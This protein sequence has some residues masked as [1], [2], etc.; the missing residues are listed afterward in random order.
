MSNMTQNKNKKKIRENV[1]L[2]ETGKINV[3]ATTTSSKNDFDFLQGKFKVHHKILKS[4]LSNSNEW[5][6]FEGSMEMRTAL[7]GIGNVENHYMTTLDG[8]PV[9]GF[10]LRLFSPSTRL[11][12]IYWANSQTG[13]LDIPVVGSFDGNKGYFFANDHFN[14]KKILLHFEWDIV[15]RSQPIWKQAFSVDEGNTWEWNWYMY[16]MK[17]ASVDADDVV[18]VLEL[19]NY[20]LRP[21]MRREFSNY[22]AKYLIQPQIDK[23]GYVLGQYELKA[24]ADNFLWLRGFRSMQSRS[25][26]LPEFYGGAVWKRHREQANQMMLNSDNV[27]LLRPLIW[28]GY[29]L[30]E[31]KGIEAES[32]KNNQG[33]T[34]IDYYI[35]N[36]K[37]EKLISFFS[38][39]YIPLSRKAGIE[40][41]TIWVSE[42]TENDFP[43]LPV[44]QDKNLLVII[45]FYKE[46]ADYKSKQA[47]LE[48]QLTLALKDQMTDLVTTKSTQILYPDVHSTI[49]PAKRT[50][51]SPKP[52]SISLSF[53]KTGE[54]EIHPSST[55]SRHDY[56]FLTGHHNVHH[57]KLKSRLSGSNEWIEFDGTK[58]TINILTGIGNVELHYMN[59]PDGSTKEGMALRLF[60]PVTRLWSLYW[61]DSDFGILDKP[62]LG[63]FENNLGVFL[64][65]DMLRGKEIIVQFQYDKTDPE[66]PTWGQAFS[67]DGG[68]TWE[69]NWF[70]FYEK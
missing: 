26:F 61:A 52:K 68:Q 42:L 48:S 37:L 15:N 29:T 10:A 3:T 32:L 13:I 21:G 69:W 12:S 28:D 2:D 6:E 17:T 8:K 41:S 65:Q 66:N 20:L 11:W 5:F 4:R 44:F 63:S 47:Q 55:S 64:A 16:F 33:I 67:E 56:D 62:Q 19:R 22:F 35:A 40:K 45:T 46:E 60:N 54:L 9:E 23:G 25:R 34:V 30:V 70:M 24:A 1:I 43:A 14:G 58:E 51:N 36:T 49:V 38:Q 27:Y 7:M 50:F 57:K 18:N 59:M 53:K 31:G 39:H